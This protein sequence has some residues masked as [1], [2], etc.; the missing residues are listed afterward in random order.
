M[1]AHHLESRTLRNDKISVSVSHCL[2]VSVS[3][4]LL[5]SVVPASMPPMVEPVMVAYHLE[6]GTLSATRNDK[7]SLSLSL[8]V[9]VSVSLC[10][11]LSYLLRCHQRWSP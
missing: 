2:S 10:L 1:A 9:S 6:S 5:L 7:I 8:S 4:S 3:L 11:S